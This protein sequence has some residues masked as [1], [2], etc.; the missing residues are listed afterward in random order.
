MSDNLRT[1]LMRIILNSVSESEEIGKPN[2]PQNQAFTWIS[3]LDTRKVCPGDDM[4][5]QRY[6]LAVFYYSTFGN[7]WVQCAAPSDFDDENAIAEANAN[8]LLTVIPGSG[9]DAW[10]TPSDECQWAGAVCD[11]SGNVERL[12]IGKIHVCSCLGNCYSHSHQQ[13]SIC[14]EKWIVRSSCF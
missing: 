4:L 11:D 8:C 2:T 5:V 3:E 12:D 1:L 7:R 13:L 9:T 6:T 14:R 10:L